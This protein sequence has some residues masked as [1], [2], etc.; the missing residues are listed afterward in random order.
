MFYHEKKNSIGV[1]KNLD[2]DTFYAYFTL[3]QSRTCPWVS[4]GSSKW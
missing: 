4:A 2:Y 1:K 3:A